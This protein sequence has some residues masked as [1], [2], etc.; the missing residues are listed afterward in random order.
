VA[1]AAATF[2]LAPGLFSTTTG[3]P[4]VFC[5]SA[6]TTRAMTS[7]VPP[8]GK[9]TMNLIGFAGHGCCATDEP[10]ALKATTAAAA[11]TTRRR[12]KMDPRMGFL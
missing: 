11:C 6:A 10:I 8:G 7:V 5:N 3:W 12:E 1:S 2:P 4:S 9:P